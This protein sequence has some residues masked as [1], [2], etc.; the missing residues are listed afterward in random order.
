MD[1]PSAR[2]SPKMSTLR[3]GEI[4][5]GGIAFV[6]RLAE[7]VC[8]ASRT[9][10]VLLAKILLVRIAR[11]KRRVIFSYR[12]KEESCVSSIGFAGRRRLF[13]GY[14]ELAVWHRSDVADDLLPSV[15]TELQH[16]IR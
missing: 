5:T 3:F 2:D 7:Y 15:S 14:G 6:R 12:P 11:C 8:I 1:A 13:G 10:H 16:S 4:Q 9:L